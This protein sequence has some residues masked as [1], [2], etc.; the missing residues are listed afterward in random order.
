MQESHIELPSVGCADSSDRRV[1]SNGNGVVHQVA[2]AHS[3]ERLLRRTGRTARSKLAP[4]NGNPDFVG[5]T[6]AAS[7]VYR[8]DLLGGLIHEYRQAA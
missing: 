3:A 1:G 4:P 5:R 8:H 6:P 7:G 2:N